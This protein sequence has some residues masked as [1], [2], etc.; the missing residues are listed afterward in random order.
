MYFEGHSST[1]KLSNSQRSPASNDDQAPVIRLNVG[2]LVWPGHGG[3]SVTPPPPA[4][5]QPTSGAAQ[6]P[7]KGVT[8]TS[9]PQGQ[10]VDLLVWPPV[11][12]HVV[13]PPPGGFPGRK[14][15]EGPSD[16]GFCRGA[17]PAHVSPVPGTPRRPWLHRWPTKPFPS[18]CGRT[19]PSSGSCPGR[20]RRTARKRRRKRPL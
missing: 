12:V 5:A 1:H 16:A 13:L 20:R 2:Q 9:A 11:G 3:Q 10:E 8:W 17:S 6:A 14:G 15:P 4:P 18:C 7:G 19:F